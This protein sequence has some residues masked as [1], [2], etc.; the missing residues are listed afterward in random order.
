M[1]Q[2]DTVLLK[3]A[4]RCNIDCSYCYVYHMGDDNWLKQD[5]LMS[6]ETVATVAHELGNLAASQERGFCT[7]LHGG[8][9]FLMGPKRLRSLLRAL[10]SALP[11]E[12][13]IS[14]Q[15]NGLLI[16]RE[17][18][19]I[20]SMYRTSV[21]VSIDGPKEIHDKY[22]LDHR[23]R[24]TFERV[25]QGITTL[26]SHPDSEFL[27]AGLLAVVDPNSDPTR[28]YQFFKDINASSVD[29]LYRD[30]NHSSLPEGKSD[31]RS[32][33]YGAWMAGI[34]RSYL[35]DRTPPKI[36]VLDDMLR[37][38]MG[39]AGTKEGTGTTD[40]G[41]LIVDTDGS[42]T[43]ND[44]LKSSYPGADQFEKRWEIG[45]L[46]ELL[47]SS[48]FSDYHKMQRPSAAACL[49][50]AELSICGGGMVL[51]RWSEDA[52]YDNPSIYCADQ[53]FLIRAMREHVAKLTPCD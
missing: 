32:V 24:G 14:L 47:D 36:R 50:C 51:H 17:V 43:K 23:G 6:C 33:E 25:M 13:P 12:F 44:T 7:V 11:S 5:K 46:K 53:L 41:I 27:Y 30:G 15:S 20:C 42:L 39:G 21:A 9:P 28:V 19:D 29:F 10:R 22:R 3:V 8:E 31:A 37:I 2:I 35:A 49:G 52:Q 34:L 4:S 38:I 18:L 45:N 40:Y 26:E 16:T 48:E 1:L